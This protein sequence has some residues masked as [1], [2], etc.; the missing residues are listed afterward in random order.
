[1]S[2]KPPRALFVVLAL[3]SVPVLALF[4]SLATAPGYRRFL[5]WFLQGAATLYVSPGGSGSACSLGSPCTMATAVNGS[6]PVAAC[7]DT[8]NVNGTN[9]LTDGHYTGSSGMITPAAGKFGCTVGAPL[10]IQAINDGKVLLDGG[11]TRGAVSLQDGQ[12]Y[13]TIIGINACCVGG[14]AASGVITLGKSGTKAGTNHLTLQRVGCWNAGR[15]PGTYTSDY[16]EQCFVIQSTTSVAP[17]DTTTGCANCLLEDTFAVGTGRK[18][19]QP[20]QT[21]GPITIRRAVGIHM[22]SINVGPKNVFQ[23]GYHA[24]NIL[25]ENAIGIWDGSDIPASYHLYNN[26]AP[27]PSPP[28]TQLNNYQEQN[29]DG[30]ISSSG[31]GDYFATNNR[32]FGSAAIVPNG[33]NWNSDSGPTGALYQGPTKGTVMQDVVSFIEPGGAGP[34]GAWP[35]KRRAE[36]DACTSC[37][38]GA[39]STLTNATFIGDGSPADV[40]GTGWT[41]TNKITAGTVGAL[42]IWNGA[43]ASNGA[44]LC[45]Q[46][47]DGTLTATPLWPW[48]MRQ[49][50]I[51]AMTDAGYT[52]RDVQAT[53][54]GYFGQIPAACG[55]PV[56]TP[57][58]SLTPTVTPT[59]ALPTSTPTAISPVCS[60][61]TQ[62]VFKD[63]RRAEVNVSTLPDAMGQCVNHIWRLP[64]PN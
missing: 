49:R 4:A 10:T 20:F 15:A 24:G 3:C 2:H 26:G 62:V 11:Y 60:G 37:S 8:V 45:F 32:V 17:L 29:V 42:N 16:N 19:Y 35:V 14:G 25:Y 31:T 18:Q 38:G 22:G 47:V 6:S 34:A 5:P 46:Y 59:G 33:S 39:A 55:G 43:H 53:M 58:P 7:G 21:G 61:A 52:P 51:D 1:M 23:I 57:T 27:Y 30:V 12:S 13:V 36:L 40:I 64:T 41:V 63:G 48:P 44:N 56:P 54:V 9:E 50:I 28:G